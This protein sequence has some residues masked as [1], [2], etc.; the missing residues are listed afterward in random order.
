MTKYID[1]TGQQ[2][3]EYRLSRW[4][5][6]GSSG[7][8]YLGQHYQDQ[9]EVALKVFNVHLA[10]QKDQEIFLGEVRTR[11]LKH[12][13]IVPLL[14]SGVGNY[15]MPF[16]VMQYAS[17]GSLDNR[18]IR[19][20]R[21]P[22][23]DVLSY[24]TPIAEALQYAH[25]RQIVHGAIKTT[26]IL[27]DAEDR[28][29]LTDFELATIA[30]HSQTQNNGSV[31]ASSI[32]SE[33]RD[34][35]LEPASDQYALGAIVYEWLCGKPSFPVA[36]NEHEQ[37]N[38]IAPPSLCI[39]VPGLPVEVE[40]VVQQALASD[41]AQR[42]TSV[43]EFAS[44]L[45]ATSN[46][47]QKPLATEIFQ[48]KTKTTGEIGSYAV[49]S[50][51]DNSPMAD[52]VSSPHVE[53]HYD[54]DAEDNPF[55]GTRDSLYEPT[56]RENQQE[57]TTQV[58]A[59]EIFLPATSKH[60]YAP[61]QASEERAE[62]NEPVPAT[63][64][65]WSIYALASILPIGRNKKQSF[66][67]MAGALIVLILLIS[68]LVLPFIANGAQTFALPIGLRGHDKQIG[69]RGTSVTGG[70]SGYELTP[71]S[72]ITP[73]SNS[74]SSSQI[75]SHAQSTSTSTS[76]ATPT[77]KANS[78]PTSQPT[79]TTAQPTSTP[80]PTSAPK[81]TPTPQPIVAS[82]DGQNPM[83]DVGPGLFAGLGELSGL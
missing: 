56:L 35:K 79:N 7:D 78:T 4:L 51:D 21:V 18:H 11:Y 34:E 57:T 1:L 64:A 82:V 15:D 26:N 40:Q 69:T 31:A 81:P 14:D 44:A 65:R 41:P 22:L 36:E 23:D 45:Q 5:G 74:G 68:V 20:L 60:A 52:A 76:H 10:R 80:K 43:Q 3:G 37:Q 25:D 61:T 58:K 62:K 77:A 39:L 48:T 75:N 49:T 30:H 67:T 16:L 59:E 33:Q 29:L 24:V 28:V 53:Q 32:I 8:V 50:T 38:D 13:H 6:G 83:T 19:G 73:T 63:S 66:F 17:H 46:P 55:V 9:S 71:V 27:L 2:F 54:S 42:F 47:E 72:T 12:P 70:P